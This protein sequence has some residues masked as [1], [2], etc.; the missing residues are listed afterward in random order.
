MY[1]SAIKPQP[2]TAQLKKWL[3]AT[4]TKRRA[5]AAQRLVARAPSLDPLEQ[6]EQRPELGPILVMHE[7]G[8]PLIALEALFLTEDEFAAIREDAF[9]WMR[10]TA[11]RDILGIVVTYKLDSDGDFAALTRQKPSWVRDEIQPGDRFC[12]R[13][14]AYPIPGGRGLALFVEGEF[15]VVDVQSDGCDLWYEV[16]NFDNRETV[17]LTDV[18]LLTATWAS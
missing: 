5:F 14:R 17:W 4:G 8:Y 16:R 12:Y 15:E 6:A 11:A 2:T 10:E 18:L 7:D 1:G 9:A 13:G 3:F